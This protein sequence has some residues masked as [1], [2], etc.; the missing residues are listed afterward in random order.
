[1]KAADARALED[2]YN[3]DASKDNISMDDHGPCQ[4][5][6][7]FGWWTRLHKPLV[8]ARGSTVALNTERRER[9]RRE[10]KKKPR[11]SSL[12]P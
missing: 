12:Y 7:G 6:H 9:K 10:I 3:G 5:R 8:T 11:D 1:V 2:K 4:G